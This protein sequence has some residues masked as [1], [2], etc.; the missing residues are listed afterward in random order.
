MAYNFLSISYFVETKT[1]QE[2]HK[3]KKL[4]VKYLELSLWTMITGLVPQRGGEK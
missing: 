3:E 4:K 1:Q 2:Y